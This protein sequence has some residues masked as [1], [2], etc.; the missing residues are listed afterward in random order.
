[1]QL[2]NEGMKVLLIDTNYNKEIEHE[3]I[4]R[5]NNWIDIHGF[6]QEYN[7]YYYWEKWEAIE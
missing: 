4:V 5:V 3:N 7:Q 2:A 1:M 6:I